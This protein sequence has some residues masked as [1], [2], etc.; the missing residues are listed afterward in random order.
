MNLPQRGH[1]HRRRA[2]VGASVSRVR[3]GPLAALPHPLVSVPDPVRGYPDPAGVGRVAP[4][5]ADPDPHAAVPAPVPW[6]PQRSDRP[7][8]ADVTVYRSVVVTVTGRDAMAIDRR[9]AIHGRDAATVD[10]RGAMI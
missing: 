3:R 10:R 9:A 8:D 4:A 5:A 6:Q 7:H 2:F 1:P